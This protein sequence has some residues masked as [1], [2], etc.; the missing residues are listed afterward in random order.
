[1][2][3]RLNLLL[4]Q[5][6]R[7]VKTAR[8]L[9][10]INQAAQAGFKPLVKEVVPSD[11]I[12]SK[13]KLIQSKV[14]GKV[15]LTSDFRSDYSGSS[16]EDYLG[17]PRSNYETVIDWTYYYPHSF[18]SPFAAYLLPADIYVGEEVFLEDLIEDVVGDSW[19]QGDTFRMKS[20]MATWNGKELVLN[21]PQRRGGPTMVG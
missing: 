8:T 20:C 6:K 12:K 17:E 21:L 9:K 1:M 11:K 15:E 4:H 19:N 5:G 18:P 2:D 10:M 13:F 16:M 7:I 3:L 14:T